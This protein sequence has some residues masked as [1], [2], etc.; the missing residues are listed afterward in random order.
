MTTRALTSIL[1]LFVA[2]PL[3]ADPTEGVVDLDIL[4]G[5]RTA[6]GTHMAALSIE[7]APGWKTYWRAP[8]DAGIPPSFD[9]AGSENLA[10]ASLHWPVP[11]LF[12]QNGMRSI[13]YSNRV[14]IPIEFNLDDASADAVMSG[15]VQ[16]GVCEEICIPVSLQFSA[17]LPPTG[18][19]D[20]AI[21][22]AL[23][24]RPQTEEEARVGDVTCALTPIDEGLQV[25]A[26]VDMPASSRGEVVVIEAGDQQVWVSEPETWREGDALYARS[27]MIH[28]SGGSFALNRSDVRIT[29]FSGGQSVDIQGCDAG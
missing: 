28:V 10:S 21:V 6:D 17:L 9:W 20:G 3:W 12:L 19:R 2:T 26:R 5:W 27:D 22:A 14:V 23:L 1:A 4:T 16:I 13:G 8:G 24:D 25:T 11:M 29:V 18:A 7:L 15:E